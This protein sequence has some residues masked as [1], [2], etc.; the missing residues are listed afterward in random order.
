[1]AEAREFIALRR[2]SR[3]REKKLPRRF[4]FAMGTGAS[5]KKAR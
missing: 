4:S 3:S 2:D 1:M 5:W